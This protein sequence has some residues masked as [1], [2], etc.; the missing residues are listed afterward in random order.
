[1]SVRASTWPPWICSGAMYFGLPSE[2]ARL[3]ELL[4][5]GARRDVLRGRSRGPSRSPR[6]PSLGGG[7]CRARQ[8]A[9]GDGRV[10]ERCSRASSRDDHAEVVA[11]RSA[12]ADGSDASS[13]HLVPHHTPPSRAPGGGSPLQVLHHHVEDVVVGL[14]VVE[15]GDAV[16]MRDLRSARLAEE[17]FDGT[18]DRRRPRSSSGSAP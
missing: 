17:P 16:R 7:W 14:A 5:R 2:E 6:L 15:D 10:R 11:S 9:R 8:G 13:A 1:M 12:T 18:P 3:R 4:L